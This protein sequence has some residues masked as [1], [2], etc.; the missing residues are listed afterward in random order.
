MSYDTGKSAVIIGPITANGK[1][2]GSFAF[3]AQFGGVSRVL[4]SVASIAGG[5][6][7]Q[8]ASYLDGIR[9]DGFSFELANDGLFNRLVAFE[10]QRSGQ[11]ERETRARIRRNS[12][13]NSAPGRRCRR[14]VPAHLPTP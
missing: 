6:I 7:N 4:L 14:A 13:A 8:G 12:A 10:A 5:A 11:S 2:M 9:F 3:N 1:D